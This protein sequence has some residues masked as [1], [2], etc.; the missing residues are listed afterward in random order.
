MRGESYAK[1]RATARLLFSSYVEI[2]AVLALLELDINLTPAGISLAEGKFH[3]RSVFHKS[4]KGFISLRDL[5]KRTIT[6]NSSSS[7]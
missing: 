6:Q 1:K 4:R 7:F 2:L 5:S 3:A